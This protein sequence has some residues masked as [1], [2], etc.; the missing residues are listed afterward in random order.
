MPRAKKVQN[1]VESA[2]GNYLKKKYEK[3]VQKKF[4]FSPSCLFSES[5]A[6]K[7]FSI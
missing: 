3:I 2:P 1:A 4:F 7:N 5:F 6:N